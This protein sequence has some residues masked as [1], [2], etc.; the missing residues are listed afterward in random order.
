MEQAVQD[1]I[2]G[3]RVAILGVSRSGKKFGNIAL[4]ELQTRGYQLYP[5][6]PQA[7][8]IDGVK[9]YP[10]LETL[11]GQVDGALVVL[12]PAQV[13]GVL[14]EVA[15][16][17]IRNVWLQQGAE[18]AEALAQGKQLGLN[19]VSGK[20]ILMYAQPVGG[21]HGVHRFVNQIFGKL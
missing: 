3:K 19:V 2:S 21:F 20:C 16:A 1:F 11:S 4:K 10:N 7:T 15:A 5:V 12:P 13:S 6:H 14:N 18:S 17:G 9:C 8:E